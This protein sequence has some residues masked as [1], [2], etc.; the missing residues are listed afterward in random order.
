VLSLA[1]G[2]PLGIAAGRSRRF[3]TAISPILDAMQIMPTFAYLAPLTLLFLIGPAAGVVATLIYAMP[4]AIRITALGIRDV[5]PT[6]ASSTS[7][8]GRPAL[9]SSHA[10]GVPPAWGYPGA[11]C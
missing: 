4:A 1:I 2:V 9:S 8:P 5:P 3:R 11:G 6:P 7:R 10:A